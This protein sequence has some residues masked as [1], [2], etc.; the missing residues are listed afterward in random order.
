MPVVVVVGAQWGDEGKGKVVDLLTEKADVVAR[1]AGGANAGHTI[2]VD[3]KKYITHLLPSGVLHPGTTCVLG[4]GMVVDPRVLIEEIAAFRQHGLLANSEKLIVSR[5]AHIT[6]PYHRELDGVREKGPSAVGS[7]KR[8]IGPTYESKAARTGLRVDDLL[9]PERFVRRMEQSIQHMLPELQ[10][11][12]V[13]NPDRDAIAKEYLAL[14]EQLRPY[15]GDASSYL[16]V[17]I[18]AGKNVLLEGAQGVLLDIDHGTYPYVT[19]SSTTAGGACAGLG[20][21]PTRINRVIGIVKAYATRV[22]LGPFPTELEGPVGEALR[23]QGA[24]F[25]STTGRPRRC[26]WLDIPALRIAC[27]LSGVQTLAVTKLDVLS[28]MPEIQLCV[29]HRLDGKVLEEMPVDPDDLARVEPVF[30]AWKGWPAARLGPTYEALPDAA[31]R[32]LARI[33]ELVGLP[34][35]LVS[36]GPGRDETIITERPFA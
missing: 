31:K 20:I 27:R 7:T 19:S 15:V 26:G 21:G 25:G 1:W 35:C 28:G 32:Y 8:G 11:G 16:D 34:I 36:F 3:D 13:Q 14:G 17:Q 4:E 29:G 18:R 22:G 30:E 10:R 6:M 9:H 5:Q 24:E 2:V 12:G 23:A 33:S